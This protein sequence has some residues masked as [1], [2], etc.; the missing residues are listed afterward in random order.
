[1]GSQQF[2]LQITLGQAEGKMSFFKDVPV[3]P[4][5]AILS[6]ATRFKE[7]KEPKKVH[8][9]FTHGSLAVEGKDLQELVA[10]IC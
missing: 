2:W 10:L 3:A 4:P 5:D 9:N 7:D 1:M 8:L 6:L